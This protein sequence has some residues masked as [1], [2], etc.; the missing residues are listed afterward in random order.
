MEMATDIY[1]RRGAENAEMMSVCKH[2]MFY[3]SSFALPEP[4]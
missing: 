2:S 1:S 4:Q 3:S